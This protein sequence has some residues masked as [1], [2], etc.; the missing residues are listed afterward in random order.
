[1]PLKVPQPLRKLFQASKFWQQNRLILREFKHFRKITILAVVFSILA[2]TF[3]GVSIG[4]LLQFLNSLTTPNAKAKIGIEFLDAWISSTSINPLYLISAFILLSTWMRATFNYFGGIYTESAQLN[5]ANRLRLQVFE[6]LQAVPLS[7]FAKTRSGEIMN[8]ITTEVERIKTGFGAVSY[9]FT[10]SLTVIVYGISMFFIS[11]QLSIV[12]LLVFSLLA[13][14]LSNLNARVRESSFGISEANANFNSRAS[15]FINGVRT[16]HAC[17]TQEFERR[18]FYQASDEQ[19]DASMKV[20]MA[21]SLVKPI[22]EVISTTVLIVLIIVAFTK[23]TLNPGP[24]LTFFFVLFRAVPN[25]QELNSTFAFMS[26]L[27]GSLEAIK[28]A[29][30]INNQHYFENGNIQFSKF[31]HAIDLVSV[32]FGYDT[33]NLVLSGIKLTIER[34]KMTALVGGSGAGK[35]T[36]ADLIPRFHDP[37][38]GHVFVDGVDLREYEINSLRRRMAV[39]SQDTFIFNASVWDN[40]AYGTPEATEAEIREAAKQANA[41]EFVEQMPDGFNT[42]LGDRGVR[43]SGGQRQRIAIARALLRDPEILIL[44]E[45]TSALDSVSEK[46]IQESLEKLSAGRTVIAIAHRLS[47]I[48]Q[49]DKVVV[50]EAGQI[51]EQGKYQ[52]LLQLKGKLWKYHQMQHQLGQTG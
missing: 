43:L 2:A 8:V 9:I 51:V 37:T 10:R 42:I 13:A 30:Q 11:W 36:L 19:L 27:T 48:A 26:T 14:G 22:A 21:W 29:L 20:V 5:L 46:L 33:E 6:Q 45:A 47:T 7:Y 31:R 38:E 41:L 4:F 18:R 49:A 3:E 25:I 17:G 44:D 24:L 40:I 50:L 16:V 39:V 52:D 35:T 12:C 28:S 34:G 23:F 32:D 1:M 15:E